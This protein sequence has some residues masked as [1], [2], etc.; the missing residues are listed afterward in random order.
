MIALFMAEFKY[1][2]CLLYNILKILW[3]CLVEYLVML[4]Q[5]FEDANSGVI[6]ARRALGSTDNADDGKF[7]IDIEI[8]TGDVKIAAQ[9]PLSYRDTDKRHFFL[10]EKG[11]RARKGNADA[12]CKMSGKLIDL[13]GHRIRFVDN[14]WDAQQCGGNNCRKRPI[15]AFGKNHIRRNEKSIPDCLEDAPDDSEKIYEIL[16]RH[17]LAHLAGHNRDSNHVLRSQ[18]FLSEVLR[19]HIKKLK[20]QDALFF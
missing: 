12:F 10:R 20:I 16:K 9:N 2:R 19:S 18:L 5:L 1:D 8:F 13:A 3:A 14:Q 17:I 7:R 6:E 15:P 11:C 4:G